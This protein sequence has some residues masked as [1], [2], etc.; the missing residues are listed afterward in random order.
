MNLAL[1]LR[2]SLEF[3]S[4]LAG[5]SWH[6]NPKLLQQLP[7]IGQVSSHTLFNAGIRSIDALRST[8]E[9]RIDVLLK[10]NP[11]FGRN[12]KKKLAEEFP[13]L[14][15][16]CNLAD[17]I[18]SVKAE[19]FSQI[20]AQVHIL[21]I[22]YSKDSNSS[23]RIL[24]HHPTTTTSLHSQP[25]HKSLQIS[26]ESS[27]FSCSL[28]FEDWSGLNQNICFDVCKE[29][30]ID[31]NE[32][33]DLENLDYSDLSEIDIST[34]TKSESITDP[35]SPTV[36]VLSARHLQPSH[37]NIPSP[38]IS[39]SSQKL[40]SSCK[41]TC[42]DKLKCA[43]VC[44]KSGLLSQ[45]RPLNTEN[46]T[47]G[48]KVNCLASSKLSLANSREYLRKYQPVNLTVPTSSLIPKVTTTCENYTTTLYDEIEI[49]LR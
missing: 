2:N 21:V 6:T 30:E 40:P 13:S 34:D 31:K 22:A 36:T 18:I 37:P 25:F 15:F 8:E 29:K 49:A 5:K 14:S 35:L 12:L 32:D 33:V 3:L 26:S 27:S 11:P 23:A 46:T 9:S 42:K 24:L 45:K 17:R 39:S 1:L 19:S 48:V 47:N 44:C 10:R 43:H 20:Q 28:M 4:S 38:S 7:G 16:D 41:H